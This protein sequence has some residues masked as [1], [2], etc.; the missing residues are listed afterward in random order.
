MIRAL[1]AL[2]AKEAPEKLGELG[3]L[4]DAIVITPLVAGTGMQHYEEDGRS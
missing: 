3:S 4:L 2:L 1:A